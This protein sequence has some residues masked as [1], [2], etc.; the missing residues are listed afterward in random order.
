MSGVR[1]PPP[2]LYGE[3]DLAEP[4][5][6]SAGV[7]GELDLAEARS[8]SARIYGETAWLG[9]TGVLRQLRCRAAVLVLVVTPDQR[10]HGLEIAGEL[11][12]F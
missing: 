7:Y 12:L 8:R 9:L 1:V 10:L 3:L 2:L 5:S 11:A 4:R 6:C